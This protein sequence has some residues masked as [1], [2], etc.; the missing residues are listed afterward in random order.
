MT[1]RKWRA[2]VSIAALLFAGAPSQAH[3]QLRPLEQADWRLIGGE[4]RASAG[5]GAAKLFG[6]RASLAGTTGDLWEAANF[7]LA[8]RTGR[9]VLEAAGTAQRFFSETGRFTDA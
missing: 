8:W 2:V 5:I 6:Q 7:S 1:A 3:S 4:G 9:V